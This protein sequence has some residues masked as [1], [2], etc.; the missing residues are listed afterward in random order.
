MATDNKSARSLDLLDKDIRRLQAKAK[1]LED[2]IDNNFTY[3]QNHSAALF[4]NSLFPRKIRADDPARE[5]LLG[6][7]FQN[8]RLMNPLNKLATRLVGQAS[9]FINKL[10]DK[11]I[12]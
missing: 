7:F 10:I 5:G 8:E 9:H 6:A 2:E 1:Q 3:L 11:W 12:D 4:I